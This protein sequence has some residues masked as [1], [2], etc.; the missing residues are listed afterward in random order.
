MRDGKAY[1]LDEIRA[2][3]RVLDEPSRTLPKAKG[4]A[5]SRA[6]FL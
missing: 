6:L 2:M 1:S 3:L 5:I 4:A